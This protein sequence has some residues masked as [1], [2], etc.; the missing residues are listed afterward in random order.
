MVS[1]PQRLLLDSGRQR[2]ILEV[3]LLDADLVLD[4]FDAVADALDVHYFEAAE[5][6]HKELNFIFYRFDLDFG[7]L[8]EVLPLILKYLHILQLIV[9][10]QLVE[11]VVVF[12]K[13]G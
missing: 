12:F 7:S 9:F 5:D 11:L 6:L 8:A 3:T 10:L 4:F 1:I 13:E 2:R